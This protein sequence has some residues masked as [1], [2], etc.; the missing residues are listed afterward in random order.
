MATVDVTTATST[1]SPIKREEAADIGAENS[2]TNAQ[3]LSGQ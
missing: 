1:T 3:R 2:V